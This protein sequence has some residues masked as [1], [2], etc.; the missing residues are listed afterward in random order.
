MIVI[1]I[2]VSSNF[3]CNQRLVRSQTTYVKLISLKPIV[4]RRLPVYRQY[5]NSDQIYSCAV[6]SINV[7]DLQQGNAELDYYET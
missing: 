3:I 4:N 2:E 1:N 6:S 5:F 7:S